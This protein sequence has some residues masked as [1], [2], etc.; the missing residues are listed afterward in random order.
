[1]LQKKNMVV[2]DFDGTLSAS[3]SNWEFFKYCFKHSFRPWLF[4]PFVVAGFVGK[5]LNPG[6]IWWRQTIRNFI[7]PNMVNRFAKDC[8]KKHKKNRFGWAKEQVAK[9]RNTG[10]KIISRYDRC[11]R[12]NK[13]NADKH[14]Y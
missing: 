14:K 4:L 2:F 10:N 13:Y 5:F 9:E 11:K 8:I 7:T 3:D 6:G 12:H 1:M